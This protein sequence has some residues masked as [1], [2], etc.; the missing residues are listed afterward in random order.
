MIKQVW[1][2]WWK[3]CQRNLSGNKI[4]GNQKKLALLCSFS[5]F[6]VSPVVKYRKRSAFTAGPTLTSQK[7]PPC[8]WFQIVSTLGMQPLIHGIHPHRTRFYIILVQFA[9]KCWV[10]FP[11]SVLLT[12]PCL[13]KCRWHIMYSENVTKDSLGTM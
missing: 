3:E 10:N 9:T 13:T 6:N 12:L 1:V 4:F 11:S 5:V 8:S 2:N 7:H